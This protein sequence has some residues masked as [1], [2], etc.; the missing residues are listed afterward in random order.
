MKSVL[1]CS[2]V[3]LVSTDIFDVYKDEGLLIKIL[4]ILH[5]AIS[6][7]V[8]Y[9]ESIEYVNESKET[10]ART[11]KYKLAINEKTDS[12]IYGYLCKD[13]ELYYK[14]FNSKTK[15]SERHSTPY[16][17]SVLFYFDVY[18]ELIVFHTANR[19][20]RKEFN[21][22]ITG[23]FNNTM[24]VNG[25][26]YRFNVTLRTEGLDVDEIEDELRNIDN[27]YELKFNY[28]PPN[29]DNDIW[30]RIRENGEKMLDTMEDAHA[31]RISQVFST[32]GGRGLNLDSYIMMTPTKVPPYNHE[33]HIMKTE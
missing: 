22:A 28:Q 9:E 32:K 31:T 13:S 18:K 17:E 19:L 3:N 15:Q 1:Y 33:N 6:S 5:G 10:V 21:D 29:P 20:G 14:T 23:I 16:T 30:N 7:D 8:V 24:E 26:D 4:S 27:I 2:K 11:I 12:Y 25:N